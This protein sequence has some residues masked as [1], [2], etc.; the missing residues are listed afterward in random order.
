MSLNPDSVELKQFATYFQK[1]EI[2]A[3]HSYSGVGSTKFGKLENL[4][5]TE[6]ATTAALQ[7]IDEANFEVAEIGAIYLGNFVSGFLTG[8][9]VLAG[10]VADKL[11]ISGV[12]ATKV[13]ELVPLAGLHSD[14]LAWRCYQVSVM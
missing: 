7:A 8:Q 14:M 2:N 13:E 11:G 9:E 4:S 1:G 5:A 10:L 6:L 12:P 3:R